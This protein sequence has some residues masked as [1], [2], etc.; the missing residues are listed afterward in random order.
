M[1][2]WAVVALTVETRWVIGSCV[3]SLGLVVTSISFSRAV[4]PV[5]TAA[6]TGSPSSGFSAVGRMEVKAA[7]AFLLVGSGAAGV[8][9]RSHTS[10]RVEE[11]CRGKVTSGKAPAGS[12]VGVSG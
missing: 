7:S 4:R 12:E 6:S 11:V 2:A 8:A 5:S 1:T 9:V 3:V 10:F